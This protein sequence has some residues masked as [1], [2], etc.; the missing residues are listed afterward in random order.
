MTIPKDIDSLIWN[1]EAGSTP[2]MN[3]VIYSTLRVG[4]WDQIKW[5]F[6]YYGKENVLSYINTDYF[7]NRTLP[8]SILELWAL[9]FWPESMYEEPKSELHKW[10]TNRSNEIKNRWSSEVVNQ[11][12]DAIDNSGLTQQAFSKIVGTSQSR[13]SSYLNGKVMPSAEFLL[14]AKSISKMLS[15]NGNSMTPSNPE[16]IDVDVPG[17]K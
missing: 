10:K 2:P 13:L 17:L 7:G 16:V 11:L 4:S 9:A 5:L 14:R 12:K 6:S 3:V 15:K 8:N 1:Y